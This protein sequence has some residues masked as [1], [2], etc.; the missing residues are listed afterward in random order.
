M[1]SHDP[2]SGPGGMASETDQSM[3]FISSFSAI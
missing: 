1:M 3:S 2:A